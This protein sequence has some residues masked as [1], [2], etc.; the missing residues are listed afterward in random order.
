MAEIV[1]AIRHVRA[2]IHLKLRTVIRNSGD[3]H[4]GQARPSAQI[5][6]T[7]SHYVTSGQLLHLSIRGNQGQVSVFGLTDPSLPEEEEN[8]M[9]SSSNW[10]RPSHLKAISSL[11]C[12]STNLAQ[13]QYTIVYEVPLVTGHCS[14][15]LT[16]IL[17]CFRH[18]C[19]AS[20]LYISY[21]DSST[22]GLL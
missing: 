18:C 4:D 14:L 2:H 19:I 16:S 13:I 1:Q 21:Y 22:K 9:T 3:G 5:P 7:S 15:T 8:A 11:P 10:Q 20:I 6:N 17:N 12:R